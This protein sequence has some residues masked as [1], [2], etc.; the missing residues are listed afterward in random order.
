MGFSPH[1][2]T[3]AQGGGGIPAVE[4]CGGF[5]PPQ[6]VLA[7][8]GRRN[9]QRLEAAATAALLLACLPGV[10]AAGTG[11]MDS[12]RAGTVRVGEIAPLPAGG[13]PGAPVGVTGGMAVGGSLEVTGAVTF[14]G[15]PPSLKALG[16]LSSGTF[17]PFD[18]MDL[19][20]LAWWAFDGDLTDKVAGRNLTSR[21]TPAYEADGI[22]GK[23]VRYAT[24][25]QNDGALLSG[26]LPPVMTL[27][28]WSRQ[29]RATEA[30][31]YGAETVSLGADNQHTGAGMGLLF[32]RFITA[33]PPHNGIIAWV[34]ATPAPSNPNISLTGFAPPL[35]VWTHRAVVAGELSGGSRRLRFYVDGVLRESATL[36]SAFLP[37]PMHPVMMMYNNGCD[38]ADMM[39]FKKALAAAEVRALYE[40]RK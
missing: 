31:P 14:E 39:V 26:V 19:N 10:A 25:E 24:F 5:Q 36:D 2:G 13:G 11:A 3:E 30:S 37:I 35:G 32:S 28:W 9:L 18:P 34:T 8:G 29:R 1:R 16:D 22:N 33:H 17:K 6:P 27:A 23:A 15:G 38:W 4:S 20:P 12:L 40:W 7:A 21:V